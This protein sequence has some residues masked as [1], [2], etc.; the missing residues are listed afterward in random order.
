MYVLEAD[1][2]VAPRAT[3]LLPE[4][5]HSLAFLRGRG[6][7]DDARALLDAGLTVHCD[8]DP[9][10]LPD[11]FW[12]GL[13]PVASARLVAALD[14]LGLDHVERFPV[15]VEGDEGPVATGF[16]ALNVIGRVACVDLGASQVVRVDGRVFRLDSLRLR[17]GL[18]VDLPL[19]RPAEWP[20]VLLVRDEFA[21][22]LLALNASGLR[23]TPSDAW[24]F[25]EY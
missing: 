18:P 6:T 9:V 5:V 4:P 24:A 11:W 3:L 19:F 25:S 10:A 13:A 1:P 2:E 14:A 12:A 7:E 8:D 17:D 21:A 23:L 16:Y 15:T 22:A 20:L